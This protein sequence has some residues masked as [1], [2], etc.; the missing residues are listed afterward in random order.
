MQILRQRKY[1]GATG[2]TRW[3]CL[4]LCECG[5]K[6]FT[7]RTD[8]QSGN[9][10]SCGCKRNKKRGGKANFY[11]QPYSMRSHPAYLMY[12]RWAGMWDRCTNPNSKAWHRYGGRGIY[13]CDAWK[14][15][16][17]F[18]NDMGQPP[19]KGASIDRRDNNGPYNP[20]NCRWATA[21]EQAANREVCKK[22]KPAKKKRELPPGF[23]D[24]LL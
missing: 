9:T 2:P 24:G 23:M 14:D 5:R 17:V 15:F 3:R 13:V 12:M 1:R 18:L 19:F 7:W 21:A 8:V 11:T 16:E 20:E 10:S 4:C 22:V 6:F